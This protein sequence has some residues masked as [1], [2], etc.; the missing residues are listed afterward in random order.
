MN[1]PKSFDHFALNYDQWYETHPREYAL[2]L[3][4]IRLLLPPEGSGVEIGAGTGRFSKPLGISLGIEPSKAMRKIALSRGV[5][6]IAGKAES[7]PLEDGLFDFALY[8]TSDCFLESL[9]TAY[10]EVNRI[11]KVGGFVVIGLID[12]NSVLGKKYES[13]KNESRFYKNANFHTVEEI[14]NDLIKA[15]FGNIETVQAILPD[16]VGGGH[17]HEV[18]PGYGEGSFVVLRAQKLNM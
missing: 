18:K 12:K 5:N 16:D 7:L 14:Q 10:Q 9:L 11:L 13:R 15:G 2:E 6:V 8:V 3:Q 1:N 17:P 4:A